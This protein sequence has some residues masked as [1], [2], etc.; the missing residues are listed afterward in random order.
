M[1]SAYPSSEEAALAEWAMYP[2]VEVFV[3]EIIY[4]DDD[5]AVVV[6]DTTPSHP[7]WNRI[8]REASGWVYMGDHN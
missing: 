6:T 8:V 5:H 3:V 1:S 7:M 4:E 2:T